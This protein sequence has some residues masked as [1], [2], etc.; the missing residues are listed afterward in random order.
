MEHM[1]LDLICVV[2][3]DIESKLQV[4]P[5]A[6]LSWDSCAGE[7]G[8][9]L[10]HGVQKPSCAGAA[11]LAACCAAVGQPQWVCGVLEGFCLWLQHQNF[12]DPLFVGFAMLECW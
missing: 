9:L 4:D 11:L 12:E 10:S 6:W 7:A 1:K 5:A 2:S 8:V 3:N